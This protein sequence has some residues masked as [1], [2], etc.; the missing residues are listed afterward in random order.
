MLGFS[1]VAK[2][3]TP[4]ATVI[5][6]FLLGF[7]FVGCSGTGSAYANVYLVTLLF[8]QSL[9][10]SVSSNSLL[11]GLSL[12]AGY[13]AMCASASEST[14]CSMASNT[15]ALESS[16]TIDVGDSLI[17]LV[18]LAQALRHVCRPHLLETSLGLCL[19][20][21]VMIAWLSVPLLPGKLTVRRCACAVAAATVLVW[22]LGAMLQH[23]A[24]AGAREFSQ[25]ALLGIVEVARGTRAEAMSWTAFAFV[26]VAFM[27]FAVECAADM[28]QARPTKVC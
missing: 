26:V 3:A 18:A 8:N 25:A 2:C 23:Q 22:G 11:P 28:R 7:L 21:L 1:F 5:A 16:S 14:V 6:V 10:D 13:M 27:G 4:V 9:A 12:A 20:L 19:G 17:S 24:V 15:S